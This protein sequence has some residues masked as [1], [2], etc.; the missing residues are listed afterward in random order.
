MQYPIRFSFISNSC[1]FSQKSNNLLP[2]C[3]MVSEASAG[4]P[5][6]QPSLNGPD[7][8]QTAERASDSARCCCRMGAYNRTLTSLTVAVLLFWTPNNI[9]YFLVYFYGYWNASF[10]A[11][12]NAL[13]YTIAWMNPVLIY[14]SLIKQRKA[15]NEILFCC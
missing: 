13:V 1:N 15:V 5:N 7:E 9:Y 10:F 12:Q 14:F 2:V 6:I 8:E 11:I 3:L 4:Q